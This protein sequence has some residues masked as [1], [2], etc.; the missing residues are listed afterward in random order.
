LGLIDTEASFIRRSRQGNGEGQGYK[1]VSAGDQGLLGQHQAVLGLSVAG[2]DD[3]E[4]GQLPATYIQVPAVRIIEAL[5]TTA[6]AK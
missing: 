6:P 5:P 3:A 4:R 1:R 2:R